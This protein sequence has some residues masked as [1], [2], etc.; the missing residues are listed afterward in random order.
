MKHFFVLLTSSAILFSSAIAKNKNIPILHVS[1]VYWNAGMVYIG[2]QASSGTIFCIKNAGE[3]TLV[4][5]EITV[6]DSCEFIASVSLAE[7]SLPA[8]DSIIFSFTYSPVN[9]GSDSVLYTISTNVDTVSI[10]LMGTGYESPWYFTQSFTGE[11]FPP[12]AWLTYD[13]DN[14][15]NSWFRNDFGFLCN[16][17][18]ACA[19][20]WSYENHEVN[21]YLIMHKMHVKYPTFK[22]K[23]WFKTSTGFSEDF[24][25]LIS[26]TDS[27][28]ESFTEIYSFSDCYPAWTAFHSVF[29]E[30]YDKDIWI[31]IRHNTS[32]ATGELYIDD[33]EIQ[34]F[35]NLEPIFFSV[36]DTIAYAD[37]VYTYNITVYNPEDLEPVGIWAENI[38]AFLNLGITGNGQAILSGLALHQDIGI[39]ELTIAAA[40]PFD[41]VYQHFLLKVLPPLGI[42]AKNAPE[43]KV[44]PNPTGDFLYIANKQTNCTVLLFD[45]SGKLILERLVKKNNERIELKK[46]PDG[47]YV[48]KTI[49]NSGQV[50]YN[51]IIIRR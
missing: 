18:P 50:A 35:P 38:P 30:Y 37:S 29:T 32:N 33:F 44:W 10:C 9:D 8:G 12:T 22:L 2:E 5:S 46:V 13:E 7:I 42:N 45:I 6:P 1:P 47:L 21:N 25:L 51:K 19:C 26:E 49:L 23:F 40:D 39:H 4:V 14:D 28:P 41:T 15:G 31:A 20:S 11:V 27:S 43:I 17:P 16:T 34:G 24:S 36:P 3:G 48:L